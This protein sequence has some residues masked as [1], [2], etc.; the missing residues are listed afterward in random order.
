MTNTVSRAQ[1]LRGNVSP[2]FRAVRAP[3]SITEDQFV[4]TCTRS[5][6]CARACP[7]DLFTAGSGGFPEISFENGE[8]T[9]CDACA[10]A[11]TSGAIIKPNTPERI[12]Q[13]P[14]Q[15]ELTIAETC[16]SADNIVCMV[17]KEHCD[18]GAIRFIMPQ[19]IGLPIVD[20]E[21]CTGCGAC[22]SPCPTRAISLTPSQGI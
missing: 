15:L 6:A 5:M 17:C 21:L 18:A 4:D 2:G 1:L 7:E 10:N 8:C 20:T 22:V 11:C 9:F 14:W 19:A 12:H 3:W 13:T 16:I